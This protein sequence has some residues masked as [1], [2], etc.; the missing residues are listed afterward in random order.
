MKLFIK[1]LI[2]FTL[3]FSYSYSACNFK[4][5]LGVKRDT[6]ESLNFTYSRSFGK[7]NKKSINIKAENLLNS[8]KE[9]LTDSYNAIERIYSLRDPGIKFSIGYSIN[10]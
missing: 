7:D 6:F 2:I 8:K 5:E 9:S 4:V 3:S 1:I 10:L